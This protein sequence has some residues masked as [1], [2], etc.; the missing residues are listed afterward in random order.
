MGG[1][2]RFSRRTARAVVWAAAAAASAGLAQTPATEG[3][4][5]PL[6]VNP[7]AGWLERSRELLERVAEEPLPEWLRLQIGDEAY[8]QA[9]AIARASA[10]RA[11]GVSL[12]PEGFVAPSTPATPTAPGEGRVLV[13]G[14]FG[15]PDETLRNL[16]DQASEPNVVF[17]LRGLAEGIDF[18]R[19]QARIEALADIQGGRM[20]NVVI[21]PTLF[22]RYAVTLAPTLVLERRGAG[23]VD[24]PVRVT[25]AVP[26]DWLRRQAGRAAP[27]AAVDLGRRAE[28]H[29][30]AE[31]DLILEM[32]RRLA[33][34]DFESRR[35]AAIER[36]WSNRTFVR[37]P[38]APE[39]AA[40]EIDPTVRVTAD[41]TDL[42]GQ[43]LVAA[44]ER[45]NPLDAVPFTKTVVVFRGTDPR[46]RARAAELAGEVRL[47][48]RGVILLTTELDTG[49]GWDG[50]EEIETVLQGP[51][52]L[53]FPDVAERF[54]LRHVPSTVQADGPR[55][56]VREWALPGAGED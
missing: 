52:Y 35:Q 25:G 13:F 29:E 22:Q 47:A 42:N 9:G 24:A 18:R 46:H 8:Q 53:L 23:G 20:P 2:I 19:T 10:A 31:A 12:E 17:V 27:D 3:G 45:F 14:T 6:G 54:H 40:F 7:D 39:D 30:I 37:L 33:A 21:D 16:L 1:C 44:G 41:I 36:F 11:A 26:V 4:P 28:V 32:Q 55:L 50:L 15:M 48:G 49:A 5:E 43:V 34:T 38:D 51:V 56:I